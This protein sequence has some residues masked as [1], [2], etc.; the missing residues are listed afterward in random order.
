MK[1]QTNPNTLGA[2][3]EIAVKDLQLDPKNPRRS[4]KT[5]HDPVLTASIAS[6]GLLQNLGVAPSDKDA[7][8]YIVKYGSRRLRSL[9]H[10]ISTGKLNDDTAVP[11]RMVASDDTD[12]FESQI[13]E[14]VCRADMAPIDLLRAKLSFFGATRFD[15]RSDRWLRITMFQNAPYPD[16]LPYTDPD[17]WSYPPYVEPEAVTSLGTVAVHCCRVGSP[18]VPIGWCHHPYD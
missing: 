16:E 14:N 4:R 9:R 8:K 10:L 5:E 17:G 6:Q 1:N 7:T 18:A 3:T 13:A 11:C 15:P 2:I 12:T